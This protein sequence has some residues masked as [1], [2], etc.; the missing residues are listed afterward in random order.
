MIHIRIMI[1]GVFEK[2]LAQVIRVVVFTVFQF[3][4]CTEHVILRFKR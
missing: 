4:S 1:N 3:S 2:R